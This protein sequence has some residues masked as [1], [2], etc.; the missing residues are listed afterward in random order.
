MTLAP[1]GATGGGTCV[2][3]PPFFY[4]NR[5]NTPIGNM[6]LV[7]IPSTYLTIP[8]QCRRATRHDLIPFLSSLLA[9]TLVGL[10]TFKD[11]KCPLRGRYGMRSWRYATNDDIGRILVY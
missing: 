7:R 3:G 10:T 2:S 1:T 9:F 8:P 5:A 4:T 11:N 6:C